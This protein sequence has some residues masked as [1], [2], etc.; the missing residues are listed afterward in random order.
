VIDTHRF[1]LPLARREERPDE[2]EIRAIVGPSRPPFPVRRRVNPRVTSF[3]LP[4]RTTF[5]VASADDAETQVVRGM[6]LAVARLTARVHRRED[7]RRVMADL[8]Q[9]K[10]TVRAFYEEAFNNGDPEGAVQRYLGDRY[11][12]HNPQAADGPE[13]FIGFVRWYRGEFPELRLEIKRMIAEGDLVVTHS[14]LTTAPED[15]GTAA[16]DIFRVEDGKVVEHW[17]VLQPVPE[18]AANDNTMF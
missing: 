17:D 1:P 9:N 5:V 18:E 2:T 6:R 8:E 11:V 7:G 16:A 13:A 12:Q 10:Q 14:V 15:R 4:R 3:G